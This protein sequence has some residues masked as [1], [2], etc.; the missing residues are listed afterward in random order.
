MSILQLMLKTAHDNVDDY[1]SNNQR[2]WVWYNHPDVAMAMESKEITP[3]TAVDI[4]NKRQGINTDYS[5][6]DLKPLLEKQ[7]KQRGVNGG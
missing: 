6:F 4:I 2:K 3:Y 7:L 1:S 5:K